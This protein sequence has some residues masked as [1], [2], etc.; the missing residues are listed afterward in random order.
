MCLVVS[1]QDGDTLTVRC[2]AAAPATVQ[3]IRISAIDAP[4]RKQA[5]GQRSRMQLT[6]LCLGQQAR[7]Q[8]LERDDY[9]RTVARVQC[10]GQDVATRQVQTGM[11]WVYTQ[12][13]HGQPELAGLEQSARA[14]RL[15]LWSQARP[16]APWTYRHRRKRAHR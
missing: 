1:V 5:F 14:Q 3:R 10:S 15:G 6:Q 11:A 12:Y 2:S 8:P 7:V 9:G 16:L 4:E 13:A